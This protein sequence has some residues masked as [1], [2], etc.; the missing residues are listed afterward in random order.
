[1]LD[2]LGHSSA[3]LDGG[4]QAWDGPLETGSDPV[5]AAAD[6]NATTAIAGEGDAWPRDR[7]VEADAIP[8]MI[9]DGTCLLDAR[10][11]ER[12]K[13]RPNPVDPVAG[14]IPGGR[15]RPW[16]ENT[17]PN[18]RFFSPTVLAG[19]FHSVGIFEDTPWIASCGSGVT[20]C[21]N[22]LAARIA[23]MTGGRLYAGSWSEWIQDP[24]RPVAV[25]TEDG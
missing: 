22:L 5:P 13:G 24:G 16:S 9:A 18:G 21:H 25:G 6:S 2:A 15:S 4:I 11:D 1:M 19:Q 23:G 12:F 14:H 7:F 10:N 20:A 8:A 17:G 3:V